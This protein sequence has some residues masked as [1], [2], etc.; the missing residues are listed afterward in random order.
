L[1]QI[2][3]ENVSRNISRQTITRNGYIIDTIV[4]LAREKTIGLIILTTGGRSG[5]RN[6]RRDRPRRAMLRAG[7]TAG[8]ENEFA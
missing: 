8:E 1:K 7:D 4:S 2:S 5:L 3:E 6:R